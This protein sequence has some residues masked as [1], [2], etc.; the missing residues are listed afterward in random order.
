[1]LVATGA[2]DGEG[3]FTTLGAGAVCCCCST[4]ATAGATDDTCAGAGLIFKVA[5]GC[6]TVVVAAG[7]EDAVARL[8]DLVAVTSEVAVTKIIGQHNED[9]WLFSTFSGKSQQ[10]YNN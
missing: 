3:A 2:G 1:M 5:T 8:D 4:A 7:A 9:I 10:N 6:C